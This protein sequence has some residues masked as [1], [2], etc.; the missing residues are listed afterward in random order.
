[1]V[2]DT[3]RTRRPLGRLQWRLGCLLEQDIVLKVQSCQAYHRR[4]TRKTRFLLFGVLLRP[5]QHHHDRRH[6]EDLFSGHSHV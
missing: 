1:M 2:R 6:A 5:F 4:H 3:S